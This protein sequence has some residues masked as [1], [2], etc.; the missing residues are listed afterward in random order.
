META[1]RIL[2]VAGELAQKRGLAGVSFRDLAA[3]VGVKSASVH[4]HFPTKDDLA[5]ALV[6]RYRQGFEL[7]REEIDR[8]EPKAEGKLKRLF[9]VL[10]EMYAKGDRICLAAVLAGERDAMGEGVVEELVRFF[11]ENERWLAGVVRDGVKNGEF[12]GVL[13][14]EGVGRWLFSMVEGAL[15]SARACGEPARIREAGEMVVGMLRK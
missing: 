1:E 10:S 6:V 2:E 4:Y 12:R 8:K 9:A 13:L 15:I 5:K 11:E 14:E 3:A 7:V